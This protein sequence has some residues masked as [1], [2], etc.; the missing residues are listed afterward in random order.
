[1]ALKILGDLTTGEQLEMR[2]KLASFWYLAFL[3]ACTRILVQQIVLHAVHAAKI[4]SACTRSRR[5][6]PYSSD[7]LTWRLNEIKA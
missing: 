3:S 6:L 2:L 4:V 1:M 7:W 5:V